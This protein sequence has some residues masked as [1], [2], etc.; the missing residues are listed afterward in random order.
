MAGVATFL[1]ALVFIQDRQLLAIVLGF[2]GVTLAATTVH[3]LGH[4]L[5]GA[6]QGLRFESISVGPL[7]IEKRA[8]NWKIGG[9]RRLS[10]GLTFMTLDRFR[11]VRRRLVIFIAGGPISSF[12][13][14]TGAFI[15]AY[16][17]QNDAMWLPLLGWFGITSALMGLF[18]LKP[19]RVGR[20]SSDGLKLWALL[21][22]KE[23]FAQTLAA[24]G[25]YILKNQGFH[26]LAWNQ[27]WVRVA[28]R[29][30]S[31]S[32][33]TCGANWKAYSE[34][35]DPQQATA[36]LELCL[37]GCAAFEGDTRDALICEAA[38]ASA[39]YRDNLEQAGIWLSR[40]TKR[41][42]RDL[43]TQ[44]RLDIAFHCARRDFG[45]A[46][47]VWDEGLVLIHELSRGRAEA[48]E[49]KW[50]KWRD[51]IMERKASL[52]ADVEMPLQ[53]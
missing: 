45:Q 4:W 46:L 33:S 18:A 29:P 49:K 14:A 10:G 15:G 27:R 25:I 17:M 19:M 43:Y 5:A 53:K 35:E 47:V 34:S 24:H 50:R 36:L 20:N 38:I 23:C 51:Q 37:A 8:D 22:S 3:E 13:A 1:V 11:R 7:S 31:L 6:S 42:Q 2:F 12:I 16:E 39:W 40:L 52:T 26:P 28:A 41:D 44:C 21:R 32:P 30:T 9:R 48:N